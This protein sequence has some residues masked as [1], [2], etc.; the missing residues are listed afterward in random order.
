MQAQNV[1][2]NGIV[3]VSDLPISAYSKDILAKAGL[4]RVE[5][6]P[7]T[8][9]ALNLLDPNHIGLKVFNEL[10]R[11]SQGTW[12]AEPSRIMNPLERSFET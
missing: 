12:P 5:Q 6:I 9:R 1:S 4:I 10:R 2:W 8:E 3:M 11:A 7:T